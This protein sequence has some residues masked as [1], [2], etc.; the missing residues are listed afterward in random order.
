MLSYGPAR[1]RPLGLI[2][3]GRFRPAQ[4]KGWQTTSI[5]RFRQLTQLRDPRQTRNQVKEFMASTS[6][7]RSTKLASFEE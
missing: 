7:I 2:S 6:R 4:R 1:D 5:G 3:V